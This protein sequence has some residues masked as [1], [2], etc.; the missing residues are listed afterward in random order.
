MVNEKGKTPLGVAI[1]DKIAKHYEFT[2]KFISLGVLPYWLHRL[3]RGIKGKPEGS[4]LDLAC[5]TG[6]LFPFLKEHFKTVVGLDYSLPMLKVAGKKNCPNCYRVRGD[7]LRLPFREKSFDTVVVSL[8]LRH[9]PDIDRALEEIRRVLK[10]GGEVHILE[11]GIPENKLLRKLFLL[12]LQKV[13]LPLGK[14]RAKEEVYDHLFGSIVKFPH[15]RE[16]LRKLEGLGFQNLTYERIM[17]GIAYVYRGTLKS[18][19]Q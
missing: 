5:G 13:V 15:G 16:L 6:I 12:F 2:A 4:V 9:F 3:K 19:E 11:V 14:L 10:E 7:A 18:P 1:F 17:F 8:G